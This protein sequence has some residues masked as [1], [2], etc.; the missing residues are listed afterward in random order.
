VQAGD[1]A[2]DFGRTAADNAGLCEFKA[3][4]GTTRAELPYY[5]DP[6]REGI[7]VV[8]SNSLKYRLFTAAFRR[9][10]EA[11]TVRLGGRIFRHFG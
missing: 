1:R 4:W 5:F 10:P 7:S 11:L 9:M 8:R 6:P 3:R 2:Y